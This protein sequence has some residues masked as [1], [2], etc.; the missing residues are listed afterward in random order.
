M[1]KPHP[2]EGS[3]QSNSQSV[4]LAGKSLK[5]SFGPPPALTRGY[6]LWTQGSSLT[7]KGVCTEGGPQHGSHPEVL[8]LSSS[9]LGTQDQLSLNLLNINSIFQEVI[10]FEQVHTFIYE[11]YT[12]FTVLLY[13]IFTKQCP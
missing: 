12:S 3:Q 13:Y 7:P 10:A 11:L 1:L 6:L 8:L 4:E 2:G 9:D 5:L